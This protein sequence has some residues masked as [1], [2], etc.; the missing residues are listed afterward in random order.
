MA[1]R[2]DSLYYST[3]LTGMG[4]CMRYSMRTATHSRLSGWAGAVLMLLATLPGCTVG[5]RNLQETRLQYNEVLKSTTEQQLLLNI[6]RLRYTDTPSS[7]SVANIAA[8]YEL[9]KQLQITPFF[10]ASGAEPNRSF[11]AILPQAGMSVADR[12]TFSFVPI[13]DAE[14]T[15]KLFTPITLDGVLYLAN[16]TW[17]IGTVFRLYLENLNWV[18][19]AERASGP[20]PRAPSP[21]AEFVRGTTALQELQDHAQIVFS[22]EE[23]FEPVGGSIPASE[24]NATAVIEAAKNG[25][26]LRPDPDGKYL[27]LGKIVRAPVLYIDPAAVESPAVH[28]FVNAFHLKPGLGRYDITIDSL[29][30]F[31]APETSGGLSFMDLE[32]RSLLQAMYFVSHG[33]DVPPAHRASG[34]ARTTHAEDG[35]EF[36]WEPV[37]RGL[38]RAHWSKGDAPPA[39]AHVAVFYQGY[40]FYIDAA[41]NDTKSTFSL[42]VELSRL[43]LQTKGDR[44]LLTLPLSR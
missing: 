9:I 43:D 34:I 37:T 18:P 8:Q 17:P 30:P 4:L 3:H 1:R 35:S 11:T 27:R 26:E 5:P 15:R 16:T 12:P 32:P 31:S 33:V 22:T 19:N 20:T 7:L 44:P 38:F 41:D 10:V 25:Y 28:E 40:W 24:A 39:G 13:D 6:V 42:L 14:F 2:R 23:R 21:Y 29:L 36:D